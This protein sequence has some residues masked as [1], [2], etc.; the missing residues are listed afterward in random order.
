[1]MRARNPNDTIDGI[2][3]P[4][5]SDKPFAACCEP[6]LSG[7]APP[8]TAE[9]LMRSRYTAYALGNL[10][11]VWDT[12]DPDMRPEPAD[13]PADTVAWVGLEI[14]NVRDG[15]PEDQNG[16]VEFVARYLDAGV[17][18]SMRERSRFRRL[19]GRWFYV[20]GEHVGVGPKTGRNDPCPCGSG[21]KFKKCCGG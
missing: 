8:G 3:C 19:D 4:C 2:S 14:L 12:W 21:R 9:Q 15:G 16:L 20:S 18:G 10:K 5:G 13:R 11:Y 7:S 6:C 17:P 1:M